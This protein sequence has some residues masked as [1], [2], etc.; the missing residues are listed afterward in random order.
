[1]KLKKVIILCKDFIASSFYFIRYRKLKV[2]TDS[3]TIDYILQNKC[4][5]ARYGD[6]EISIMRGCDIRFQNADKEL[7][8]KLINAKSN[9]KCLLC[10]PAIFDKHS[11]NSKKI[12]KNEF[13]FWFIYKI[14]RGGL[15][16]KYFNKNS[17]IGDAFI[18]RFYMRYDNK[19]NV[20]EYVKKL[21]LLWQDR[22]IIM[23]EG[24]ES[25]LGVG[26]DLLEGAKSIKRILCPSTNAYS[27]YNEIKASI[28]EIAK[29]NDL[30]IIALG[31][32]ATILAYELSEKFQCLDLGHVD[33]EYEWFLMGAKQKVSIPTKHVNET[34]DGRN[35][36]NIED[37][38][39]IKQIVKKI[40]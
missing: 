23:V 17:V 39:Y 3:Q 24:S 35:P 12:V 13:R 32:A 5:I 20:A 16:R 19:S 9:E 8:T 11:F 33:I 7:A 29:P 27:K 4:S 15:W 2:F 25:R 26:N 30:V 37:E 1:M 38:N 22:S 18:S 28:E 36:K 6:G 21:Q 14:L 31:P 10:I 34:K 40:G